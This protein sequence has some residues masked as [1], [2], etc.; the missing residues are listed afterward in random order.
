MINNPV[1]L[2]TEGINTALDQATDRLV[3]GDELGE[4]IGGVFMSMLSTFIKS[5]LTSLQADFQSNRGVGGPEQLVATNGQTIPWTQAPQTII[6]LKEEFPS[7]LSDTEKEVENLR[8]Y[9]TKIT[10]TTDSGKP[11]HQ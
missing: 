7:A 4:L 8:E 3:Q 11:T 2:V 6:D 5:G 9:I 1:G 10:E